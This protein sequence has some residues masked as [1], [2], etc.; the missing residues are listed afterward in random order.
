M[1][2]KAEDVIYL[3]WAPP[4]EPES[5][6]KERLRKM[7]GGDTS[8]R[9]YE[10]TEEECYAHQAAINSAKFWHKRMPL[11]I[12][13]LTWRWSQYLIHALHRFID[14]I[15]TELILDHIQWLYVGY[16]CSSSDK[17][18][19]L[20]NSTKNKYLSWGRAR[21]MRK[22]VYNDNVATRR[23][24]SISISVQ[25]LAHRIKD[26]VMEMQSVIKSN[27]RGEAL[28]NQIISIRQ[29][30]SSAIR[31]SLKDPSKLGT[32]T[33]LIRLVSI[34]F[35][36][37]SGA[38]FKHH[39]FYLH[40]NKL[41]D[42][43][44]RIIELLSN[45]LK[46]LNND[47]P[48][49]IIEGGEYCLHTLIPKMW[50][51]YHNLQMLIIVLERDGYYNKLVATQIVQSFPKGSNER[52]LVAS[53]LRQEGR[54]PSEKSMRTQLQ[55][56]ETQL[57][58]CEMG[59][60]IINQRWNNKRGRKR[61]S[62]A[63]DCWIG[64]LLMDLYPVEMIKSEIRNPYRGELMTPIITMELF[65]TAKRVDLCD[66]LGERKNVRLYFCPKQFPI[67]FEYDKSW[68]SQSFQRVKWFIEYSSMQGDS[69]VRYNGKERGR[70][71]FRCMHY[72][73]GKRCPFSFIVKVDMYGYYIDI[74]NEEYD[75]F[76]GCEFHEHK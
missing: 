38:D 51:E 5:C 70:A 52:P 10:C 11:I 16:C 25:S 41:N 71:R 24:F 26:D 72:K 54:I 64:T 6:F 28:S 36:K 19:I 40:T 30:I 57:D 56:C 46:R 1:M 27:G 15:P 9:Y 2:S 60:P 23:L 44:T 62:K 43:R 34:N 75:T 12:K 67:P 31:L 63:I 49:D 14:Y 76:I 47:N 17:E 73:E 68:D 48:A 18:I 33:E 65:S 32:I 8:V 3:T 13:V 20:I 61:K 22:N 35:N 74:Y 42:I 53:K 37:Y 4:I 59:K 45:T 39:P 50:K 66:Y 21:Y 55:W 69:P 29:R 7:P 58:C